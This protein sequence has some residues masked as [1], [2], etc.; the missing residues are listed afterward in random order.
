MVAIGLAL[1]LK[2]IP[3]LCWGQMLY[4]FRRESEYYVFLCFTFYKIIYR[5]INFSETE[6]TQCLVFFVVKR[7]PLNTCPKWPS[8][9]AQTISILLPSASGICLTAPASSSSKL[10]HPQCESN[11]SSDRYSGVLHLRHTYVPVS[12]LLVYSPVKGLSVPLCIITRSSSG[13]SSL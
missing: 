10:G 5:G 13:V 4:I 12:V 1:N 3:K 7:S 11:L 2:E 8:Q 6:F 9:A